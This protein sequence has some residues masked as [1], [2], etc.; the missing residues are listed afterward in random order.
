MEM[1]MQR[2]ARSQQLLNSLQQK[3]LAPNYLISAC[4]AELENLDSIFTSYKPLIL[5]VTQ[6]LKR[7]P[8]FNGCHP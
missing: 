8:S 7:E 2:K 6:L 5:T 3:P 4:Q 1:F